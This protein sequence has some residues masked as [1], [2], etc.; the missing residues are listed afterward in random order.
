MRKI[1]FTPEIDR[2]WVQNVLEY[3]T[4]D[5]TSERKKVGAIIIS[6]I[7]KNPNGSL[8]GQGFN[9]V[10]QVCECKKCEDET[11]A[12]KPYVMHAEAKAIAYAA[13]LGN[14]TIGATLYCTIPPCPV[15]CG[16]IIEAGIKRVIYKESYW[17][18]NNLNLLKKAGIT[19]K[20][21]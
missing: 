3:V 2:H 13:S 9:S 8:I 18:E 16:L 4:V 20:K 11:G 10:P 21:L 5:S 6:P 7:S 19:V 12:T 14:S 17:S 1:K 15:C